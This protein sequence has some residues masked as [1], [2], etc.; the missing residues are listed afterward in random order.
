MS[1]RHP[2]RRWEWASVIAILFLAAILRLGLPGV[3]EFKRDE[4][5]LSRLALDLAQGEHFPWL[6]IGSSVGFPNSPINV[7]I[8][9]LPYL[10]SDNPL[11]TTLFVG[12]LNIVAV[13]LLWKMARRYFGPQAALVSGILYAVSPWA[14]LYSRKIW[15]QDILPPFVIATVFSALLGFVERKRWAQLIHLPLLAITVQVHFGA[16]V[17]VPLTAIIALLH[18]QNWRREWWLSIGAAILMGMP[19][20]YGLYEADQLSLAALRDSLASGAV[21]AEETP[22]ELSSEALDYAWFTVAGTDIHSLAGAEQYQR[23]LNSVPS[24]YTLFKIIPLGVVLATMALLYRRPSRLVLI[25]VIWLVLPV[26]AFSY[27]WAAPQPHYMIPMMPAAFL[28]LGGGLALL[29]EYGRSAIYGVGVVLAVL[30]LLQVWLYFSLLNFLDTHDT[31]GAFGTPLHYLL[32]VR[33]DVL[34]DDPASVIVVSE[35]ASPEFDNDPAVWDILLDPVSHV[36]YIKADY[37]WLVPH[38]HASLLVGPTISNE[39]SW[40]ARLTQA[41]ERVYD[42]RPDEGNYRLWREVSLDV[43]P[44]EPVTARYANGV[45]LMGVAFDSDALWLEWLLPEPRS[46]IVYVVF[47]HVMNHAERIG[48]VDLPFIAERY[49]RAGDRLFMRMPLEI[50]QADRL[51]IGMYQVIG[52]RGFRN[53]EYV[54]EQGRYLEQWFILPIPLG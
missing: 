23:Y 40:R 42:L 17:L 32:D 3:V 34:A 39:H 6:G 50:D 35:G 31:T 47:V 22:R 4:A 19:Y 36:A 51:H 2:I 11:I 29:L 28:L 54:D 14:A 24:V 49:W 27:T 53:S 44:L 5:T 21:D 9:A 33:E 8:F 16:V 7:Y 38:D 10:I 15:A 20:V 18:R 41:P 43:P 12:F 52:E 26:I 48:Q 1:Y 13:A 30:V 37:M 46:D 45:Q 25:L